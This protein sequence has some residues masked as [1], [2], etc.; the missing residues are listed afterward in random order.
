MTRVCV[1]WGREGG[2]AQLLNSA[3][4]CGALCFWCCCLPCLLCWQLCRYLLTRISLLVPPAGCPLPAFSWHQTPRLWALQPPAAASPQATIDHDVTVLPGSVMPRLASRPGWM[5]GWRGAS[6]SGREGVGSM[7]AGPGCLSAQAVGSDMPAAGCPLAFAAA[8]WSPN[9]A[10]T[11]L[12][13]RLLCTQQA[14]WLRRLALP[15]ARERLS[16]LG[17]LARRARALLPRLPQQLVLAGLPRPAASCC[18]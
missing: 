14:G 1:E 15:P 11:P 6:G 3:I 9:I 7:C 13:P 5:G 4:R 10:T 17:R 12:L 2:G 16:P 18:A 8:L